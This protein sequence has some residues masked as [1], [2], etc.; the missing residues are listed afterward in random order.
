MI[1]TK[2]K[3]LKCQD[4]IEC[5]K[6]QLRD[7]CTDRKVTPPPSPRAKV[8]NTIATGIGRALG[9]ALI[10]TGCIVAVAIATSIIVAGY[11]IGSTFARPLSNLFLQ[12]FGM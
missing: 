9:Y 12:F 6:C 7:V 10:Y 3:H 8:V 5:S 4:A 2:P 1:D 11:R